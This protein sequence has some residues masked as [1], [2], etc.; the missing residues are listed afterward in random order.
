M[1]KEKKIPNLQK[2]MNK[3]LEQFFEAKKGGQ[4]PV[5][6]SVN[7]LGA[8][9]IKP[10]VQ[11]FSRPVSF[12]TP[13][14]QKP[15]NFKPIFSTDKTKDK[16]RGD[17]HPGKDKKSKLVGQ[18]APGKDKSFGLVGDDHLGN[19][20]RPK[21]EGEMPEGKD[22]SIGLPTPEKPAKTKAFSIP[23]G[24]HEPKD[25]AFSLEGQAHT[26]KD[27]AFGL[28]GA[29]HSTATLNSPFGETPAKPKVSV[30]TDQHGS[31]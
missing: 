13:L 31:S 11:D 15:F 25:R 26:P 16:E 20:P 9:R 23:G 17:D 24:E 4:Q 3:T 18:A 29:D 6:T 28:K 5:G 22:K 10:M 21:I 2:K 1:A 19:M 12:P 7:P 14:P 30:R 27:K 8:F